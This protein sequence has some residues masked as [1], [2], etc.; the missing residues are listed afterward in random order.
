MNAFVLF[1]KKYQIKKC[2]LQ[3]SD[4]QEKKADAIFRKKMIEW[5]QIKRR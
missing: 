4:L 3:T 5:C 2:G 1:R